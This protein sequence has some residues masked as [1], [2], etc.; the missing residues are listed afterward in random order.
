[1]S[2]VTEHSYVWPLLKPLKAIK[3]N[4]FGLLTIQLLLLSP[5]RP[6]TTELVESLDAA[7]GF[8]GISAL[9]HRRDTP[10]GAR[11]ILDNL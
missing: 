2:Y 4:E 8:H 7:H 10:Q 6:F 11:A 5:R 1:M 9:R 3:L